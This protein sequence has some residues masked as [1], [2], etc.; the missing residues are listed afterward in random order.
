M[1]KFKYGKSDHDNAME[2]IQHLKQRGYQLIVTT[3]NASKRMEQLDLSKPLAICFG[4]ESK[5]ISDTFLNMLMNKFLF[6]NM[7]LLK[8]IMWQ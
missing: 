2:C 8:A 5:G 1:D 4:Q 7:D 6:H 3:P